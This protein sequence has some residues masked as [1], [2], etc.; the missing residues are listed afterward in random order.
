MI[1]L[2]R[3]DGVAA[4]FRAVMPSAAAFAPPMVVM[5]GVGVNGGGSDSD[6]VRPRFLAEGVLTT[7]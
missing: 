5:M 4:L 3:L 1:F 7:S 6:L 2:Q